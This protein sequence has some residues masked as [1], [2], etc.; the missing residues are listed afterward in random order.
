MTYGCDKMPLNYVIS[1]FLGVLSGIIVSVLSY[2]II[3]K[4]QKRENKLIADIEYCEGIKDILREIVYT[5]NCENSKF[6]KQR[7]HAD[8]VNFKSIADTE[9][10]NAETLKNG[11][12]LA[13]YNFC[14]SKKLYDLYIDSHKRLSVLL[15][16]THTLNAITIERL[17][18]LNELL[19][20]VLTFSCT[21]FGPTRIK[22]FKE[23]AQNIQIE[24]QFILDDFSE[25]TN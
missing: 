5:Y 9:G 4:Y 15:G 3:S 11:P 12:D 10:I 19:S 20:T 18:K 2:I 7:Y 23:I 13:T 14:D 21:E 22:D 17:N 6:D 16:N 1:F 25:W 8:V 24:S